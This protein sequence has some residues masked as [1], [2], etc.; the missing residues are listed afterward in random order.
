MFF[1]PVVL[2]AVLLFLKFSGFRIT[3]AWGVEGLVVFVLALWA[4]ERT[5]RLTGLALIMLCVAKLVYDTW[6]FTDPVARYSAW[7]G[8]GVVLLLVS[9]LYGKNRE[10]LRDYL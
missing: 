5:F 2:L 4:K 7:I 3:I 6:F 10:A 8:I 1:V 9:F